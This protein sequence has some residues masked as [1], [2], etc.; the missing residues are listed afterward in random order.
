MPK[1][2]Y[3]KQ[4]A[5]LLQ[6]LIGER[7]AAGLTQRVLADRLGKPQSFVS[8]FEHGER[9]LDVVEF[10]QITRAIGV[11]PAAVLTRVERATKTARAKTAR[12]T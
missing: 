3:T 9:R 8:K 1:S 5:I 10:L 2:V 11:D 4:Y 6:A 7:K 12:R